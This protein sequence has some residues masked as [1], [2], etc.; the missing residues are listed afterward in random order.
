MHQRRLYMARVRKNAGGGG[1]GG[2]AFVQA[3]T[4]GVSTT[5]ANSA[6]VGASTPVGRLVVV[7]IVQVYGA[8]PPRAI[9]TVYDDIDGAGNPYTL[10]K[11]Q[12]AG[13]G[14]I[15]V[16]TYYRFVTTA[17][18][19]TVN[20]TLAAT[21][22]SSLVA[23]EYSGATAFSQSNGN[24]GAGTSSTPGSVTEAGTALFHVCH[25]CMNSYNAIDPDGT[26]N[27]RAEIE[28][29]GPTINVHDKVTSG[30]QNPATSIA[31]SVEWCSTISSFT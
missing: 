23:T 12:V 1:G 19:R 26:W 21:G 17:G 2:P 25:G 9:T 14:N 29:G 31:A 11:S 24:N 22:Y 6:A 28:F 27:I 3:S 30:A 16:D 15:R 18:A 7:D 8:D 10:A 5:A 20:L 13:S 4:V